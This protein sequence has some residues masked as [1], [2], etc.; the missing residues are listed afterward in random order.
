MIKIC[1]VLGLLLLF[2]NGAVAQPAPIVYSGVEYVNDVPADELYSRA[3]MWV[4]Q[5]YNSAKHVL[6]MAD[7][8]RL[9]GKANL[10][11]N[12]SAGVAGTA[13]CKIEYTLTIECR[14]GRYK[15]T[16]DNINLYVMPNGR[17]QYMD[18]GLLTDADTLPKESAWK[19]NLPDKHRQ[20]LWQT[21]KNEMEV[22]AISLVTSLKTSMKRV[23]VE[24]DW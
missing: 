18:Y 19:T 4:A 6:Q 15:Y 23:A 9:V 21:A 11:F 7:N 5:S 16:V 13:H 2:S 10:T 14:D 3:Q 17:H 22:Y 24:N 20:K 12:Y 1:G 8:N